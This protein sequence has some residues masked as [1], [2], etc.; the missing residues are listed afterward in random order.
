MKYGNS[1][2]QQE[3]QG[4]PKMA[5]N[6][7]LAGSSGTSALIQEGQYFT[8][9]SNDQDANLT[10]REPFSLE[11]KPENGAALGIERTVPAGITN[12]TLLSNLILT[13]FSGILN[14]YSILRKLF[15]EIIYPY[16]H[17]SLSSIWQ[18]Y[19]NE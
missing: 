8:V 6:W 2:L 5:G 11:I 7:T 13:P 14:Y 15:S 10:A 1:T 16:C 3:Q 17:S 9:H 19:I 12:T 18:S 4:L